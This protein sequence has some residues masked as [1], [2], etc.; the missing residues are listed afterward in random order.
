MWR[1]RRCSEDDDA[2][3]A[4]RQ[5]KADARPERADEGRS[6]SRVPS[7]TQVLS[8]GR[9]RVRLCARRQCW[10][11]RHGI[12][13]PHA[14]RSRCPM[15]GL[16][17]TKFLCGTYSWGP[18]AGR[19]TSPGR[20]SASGCSR[21]QIREESGAAHHP[22]RHDSITGR[23]HSPWGVR[24]EPPVRRLFQVERRV[25]RSESGFGGRRAARSPIS[26][27]DELPPDSRARGFRMN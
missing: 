13:V 22:P 6:P 16:A 17:K 19:R 4:A 25:P 12:A 26:H 14:R 1:A 21:R 10:A 7:G 3:K 9:Q 11:H 24:C 5:Q 27:P 18:P 20:M 8:V 2:N 23:L 15:P